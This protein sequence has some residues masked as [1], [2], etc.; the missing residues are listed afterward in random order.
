MT[1]PL[2]EDARGKLIVALMRGWEPAASNYY[3]TSSAH[4]AKADDPAR[5]PTALT[6]GALVRT[7]ADPAFPAVSYD[8]RK[9]AFDSGAHYLSVDRIKPK[10]D[11]SI[12]PLASGVAFWI[13]NTN[14]RTPVG[15]NPLSPRSSACTGNPGVL[16]SSEDARTCEATNAPTMRPTDSPTAPP[17]WK[18]LRPTPAANAWWNGSAS[19][20]AVTFKRVLTVVVLLATVLYA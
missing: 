6:S 11:T 17:V 8:R 9:A 3:F 14:S 1:W 15:C 19:A 10:I 13:P 16:E 20:P 4:V 18:T 5:V 12:N 2:I 7:R